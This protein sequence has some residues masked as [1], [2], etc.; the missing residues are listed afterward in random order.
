MFVSRVCLFTTTQIE[1][2]CVMPSRVSPVS[3]PFLVLSR[4]R[5]TDAESISQT[6][7]YAFELVVQLH[8]TRYLWTAQN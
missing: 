8:A 1:V 5:R 7:Q 3:C 4:T 2:T 6:Q